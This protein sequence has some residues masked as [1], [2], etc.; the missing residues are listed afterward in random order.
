MDT[1][2]SVP[3]FN[4]FNTKNKHSKN[5]VTVSGVEAES[6]ESWYRFFVNDS[7]FLQEFSSRFIA[8]E[9][10]WSPIATD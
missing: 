4:Q 10:F 3:V 2:D 8:N 7:R 5:C 1:N 9:D 6:F